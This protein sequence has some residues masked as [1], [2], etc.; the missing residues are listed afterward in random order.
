[1][2]TAGNLT[3]HITT[4]NSLTTALHISAIT[5]QASLGSG[6][7]AT[8]EFLINDG[9]SLARMATS[10]LQAYMQANLA[11]SATTGTV[12]SITAGD[13][14]DFTTIT[15]TGP[16]TMGTP[17]ALD[18]TTTNAVTATSHTHA[19]TGFAEISGTPAN[20]QI[21]VW[22]DAVTIEGDTD[23]TWNGS[24][25]ILGISGT[26]PYISYSISGTPG[27]YVAADGAIGDLRKV[28]S[29]T[30]GLNPTNFYWRYGGTEASPAA[31]PTNAYVVT[32]SYY[33]YDG[34]SPVEAGSVVF[35]VA[36]AIATGDFDTEYIWELKEGASAAAPILELN[37]NGLEYYASH[38]TDQAANDRWIPD[39]GY[40]DAAVG[41]AGGVSASGTPVDNQ[42]AVWT[43]ASTIEGDANFTWDGTE[44]NITGNIEL[45]STINFT[46]TNT[47]IWEDGSGNMTFKDG[48][49]GTVT[50]ATLIGGAGGGTVTSIT[51]G[52]GMDFTTITTIGP[53]T[54]GAPST[55]LTPSTTNAVTA[56][57]HTHAIT[58]FAEIA[59]TPA[60]SYL[61]VWTGA[62]GIE[63]T[64]D[65]IYSASQLTVSGNL[66]ATGLIG[67]GDR[68]AYAG[69]TGIISAGN[70]SGQVTTTNSLATSLTVSAITAQTNLA[71]G[72]VSTDELLVND[73]GVL[74][75]MEVS[76]LEAYMQ[77]ELAF[78]LYVHPNHS[79]QVTS[80]ADGAT[81]VTVSAITAQT[82]LTTGLAF[83]DELLVNDAGVISRMDISVLQTYM[84][85]NLTFSTVVDHG[86]L[87]GLGDDDHTHYYNAARLGAWTGSSNI[88]TLGT[89][90]TGTWQGG[91]IADA[92]V[93]N[94]ITITNITQITNRSHTNLSDIGS[95]THAQI[96]THIGSTANP[97][98]V[99]ETDILPA[100]ATH[101]GK[102]LTTN[103]TISSWATLNT[104]NWDTAY[105]HSQIVT[106]NP[107]VIGHADIA[108]FSTG[109]STHE[110]SHSDVVVDG[111]FSAN[112]IL[113]RT[114]AG[115][116]GSLTTSSSVDT[117]ETVLTDDDTHLP[118][119]GAVVDAIAAATVYTFDSGLTEVAGNVDLGGALTT[120]CTIL[121][122]SLYDVT[123]GTVGSP[124]ETFNI[125]SE[126][127]IYIG[128]HY[129]ASSYGYLHISPYAD[130]EIN[131]FSLS[132]TE[133]KG[134][135]IGSDDFTVWDV[136]DDTGM[137]YGA[138]YEAAGT[139]LDRWIPDYAAVKAYADSVAG[140]P[141]TVTS[142]SSTTTNQLTVATGTTTP[143]LTIVTAPVANGETALATG[144]Q[145]YD[146]VQ[147]QIHASV[148][149]G[150]AN[151][152]SLSVQQL[153]LAAATTSTTGAL[154]STD[155]NRF[156]A[157]HGWGDHAGLYDPAGTMTTH[158]STYNHANYNTAYGW[159]NHA[160]AG[161]VDTTGTPANN[162]IAVFTDA[163]TVEGD[164]DL[165]WSGSSLILG[166]NTP[167]AS[168]TMNN[169]GFGS[170]YMTINQDGYFNA[171]IINSYTN[172]A[173]Y[174]N[175][176]IFYRYGGTKASPTAAPTSADIQSEIFYAYDGSSSVLGAQWDVGVGGAIATGDF[177]TYMAWSLKEGAAAMGTKLILQ[178]YGFFY[179]ADFSG[180]GSITA[181]WLTDKGY[182]DTHL[183]GELLD[184]AAPPGAGTDGYSV[185][186]DNGANEFQLQNISG[187]TTS[188]AGSTTEIQYN[189]AGSFGASSAFTFDAAA[190]GL[191]VAA[192]VYFTSLPSDD[193]VD[194]V[195]AINDSSGILSKRSVASISGGGGYWSQAGGILSPTTATDNIAVAS[196]EFI[197]LDG[198]GDT[199]ISESSANIMDLIAGGT[200][201]LQLRSTVIY[202][203]VNF[204]PTTNKTQDLGTNGNFWRY[205][206]ADRVYIDDNATYIDVDGTGMTFTDATGTYQLSGLGGTSYDR[207]RYTYSATSTTNQ[208]PGSVFTYADL[209]ATLISSTDVTLTID[210]DAIETNNENWTFFARLETDADIYT[211][212]A[213]IVFRN[214]AHGG[215]YQSSSGTG[216]NHVVSVILMWD[217]TAGEWTL[218]NAYAV[219]GP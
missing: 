78:N 57:S 87:T 24:S 72:L 205:A 207:T 217:E 121:G 40:V 132:G 55:D 113:R 6:L 27:Y 111:D 109:V 117:V 20:N 172:I 199:Y 126:D 14:M 185:V 122:A 127:D 18:D 176:E 74:S 148:T 28:S 135:H 208:T 85:N 189:N 34:T 194:H 149:I 192:G 25:L 12:T 168:I 29:N 147:P 30:G 193:T 153:S 211:G 195:I 150:T 69:S 119:S 98:S 197:Y 64:N 215:I 58:G 97:H 138:D 210:L 180:H 46:D 66:R 203:G 62:V 47:Q 26:A 128:A 71:S 125:R 84:Q 53:V 183:W 188:P 102:Y 145:I 43:N 142:V 99:D 13:G 89:I 123:F 5:D 96:D 93:A 70:L 198:G 81:V 165:T 134:F 206:W 45:T 173:G 44:L 139:L 33:V 103:G 54:L 50:L 42:I 167:G 83:T 161:Y 196:G 186:W 38:A 49:G 156:D 204:H 61:A 79:G 68:L 213:T 209:H 110:T 90:G 4:T 108:D 200:T 76:V 169:N 202:S 166:G 17:G 184:T 157:A 112:G 3:G 59:G 67:T 100:Q 216:Q 160:S 144:D 141:G 51:A 10:V 86:A 106:G 137:V 118:T 116:Y 129:S 146:Y 23:F 32:D 7:L 133:P 82:A 151:G 131:L 171:K 191:T 164:A 212:N 136:Q 56:T 159:G 21:A 15:T 152:L 39:K 48:I 95:N 31:A 2:L 105:T 190:A 65:L 104:T 41:A 8:D 182:D 163:N 73:G 214:S 91:V 143:A 219:S 162:Q 75:R 80:T 115:T 107:H 77:A 218:L 130:A 94:D 174:S 120:D 187:G 170:T 1:M 19:V 201:S 92:Y 114:G 22:T 140:G 9:G 124:I 35:K 63:G 11:F 154:T 60:D 175:R 101:S 177:N 155:W 181:R 158:E 88:T 178:P 36:G 37:V 16:V 179:T 52:N